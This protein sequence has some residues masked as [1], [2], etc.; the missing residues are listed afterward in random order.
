MSEFNIKI[1]CSIEKLSPE[2]QLVIVRLVNHLAS[3]GELYR[4]DVIERLKKIN[5]ENCMTF[6]RDNVMTERERKAWLNL[7]QPRSSTC[8]LNFLK[9]DMSPEL[10]DM[11]TK[12]LEGRE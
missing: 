12:E 2:N 3:S 6:F 9:E 5:N 7:I 10:H 4:E 11:V 8:L 1:N